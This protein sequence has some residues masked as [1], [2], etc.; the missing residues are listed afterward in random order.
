MADW[1]SFAPLQILLRG[2]VDEQETAGPE[3]I[4]ARQALFGIRNPDPKRGAVFKCLP[5]RV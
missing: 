4:V 5:H 3:Y 1:F 2:F